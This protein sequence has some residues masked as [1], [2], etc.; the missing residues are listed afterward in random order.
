MKDDSDRHED[1]LIFLEENISKLVKLKVA[2]RAKYKE[3]DE[4][5]M[6][7]LTAES[8]DDDERMELYRDMLESCNTAMLGKLKTAIDE[9]PELIKNKVVAEYVKLMK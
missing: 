8:I 2:S 1:I 7:Y 4:C 6:D 9:N 5:Y 3:Y